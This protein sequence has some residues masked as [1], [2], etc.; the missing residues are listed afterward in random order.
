M[1]SSEAWAQR[2]HSH[3]TFLEQTARDDHKVLSWQGGPMCIVLVM[4]HFDSSYRVVGYL[5]AGVVLKV[6]FPS[7]PPPVKCIFP[8]VW[9]DFWSQKGEVV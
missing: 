2:E 3:L 1:I 5:L 8:H 6:C 7:H 9:T 4:R